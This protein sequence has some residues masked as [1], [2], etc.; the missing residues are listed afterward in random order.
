M[1]QTGKFLNDMP[2]WAKGV[3]GVAAVAAVGFSAYLIY[4]KIKNIQA[5]KDARK[6]VGD[7]ESDLDKLKKL[8]KKQSLTNSEITGIA[9]NLKTAMD[10]YGTDFDA[11]LKNLV[12][13]NNQVDLLAVIKAYGVKKLSTGKLNPTPDFEGTLGQAFTEELNS[14]QLSAVNSMLAKKGITQRF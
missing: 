3:I 10:G 14:Q 11:I 12:K 1:G 8:G 5:T 4:K 2:S 13:I 7:I 9:N 6:E